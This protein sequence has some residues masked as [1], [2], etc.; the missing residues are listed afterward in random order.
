MN[1]DFVVR[2]A[3]LTDL[4][5][6]AGAWGLEVVKQ[7]DLDAWVDVVLA[8]AN[9]FKDVNRINEHLKFEDL[10]YRKQM[11]AKTAIRQLL[12]TPGYVDVAEEFTG[13]LI[14]EENE[15]LDWASKPGSLRHLSTKTVDIYKAVLEAAWEDSVNASEFRLLERLRGKLGLTRRD[16]RVVELQLGKFPADNGASHTAKE[17]GEAIGHLERM[18]LLLKIR[19]D[20]EH[21]YCVPDELAGPVRNFLKIELQ[22]PAYLNLLKNIP[23]TILKSALETTG[24]QFSGTREFLSSR[25][26][27]SYTSPKI[28]LKLLSDDQLRALAKR[29]SIPITSSA[30]DSVIRGI[31]KFYDTSTTKN[32]GRD[33]SL[34]EQLVGFYTELASRDYSKLRAAGIINK[35]GQVEKLFE[36]ATTYLVNEYL[37]LHTEDMDGTSHADGRA[38]YPDKKHILLWDCKSCEGSYALTEKTSQQFLDYASRITSPQAACPMMIIAPSFTKE[39]VPEA[40]RLKTK[41]PIGTEVALIDAKIFLWLCRQWHQGHSGTDRR[42]IPWEVLATTGKVTEEDLKVALKSFG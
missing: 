17:V 40:K 39:S 31:I 29:L 28:V 25:L 16:H 32:S 33:V 11:L 4:R 9:E 24:Q 21:M 20:G 23:V 26:I 2:N 10:P 6:F 7:N 15:F 35:D 18:G 30:K 36:R 37:F 8:N 38:T 5:I 14:R 12:N 13:K 19:F 41:C 42:P 27:D 34:D 3:N 22:E 1:L